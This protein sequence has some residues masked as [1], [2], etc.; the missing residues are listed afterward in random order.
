MG[1]GCRS[2]VISGRPGGVWGLLCTPGCISEAVARW[3]TICLGTSWVVLWRWLYAVALLR[4]YYHWPLL[5]ILITKT[6]LRGHVGVMKMPLVAMMLPVE[7]ILPVGS[8][9]PVGATFHL[10]SRAVLLLAS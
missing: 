7:V 1:K 10:R 4:W 6:I 5:V 9:L 2:A 8:M 3:G